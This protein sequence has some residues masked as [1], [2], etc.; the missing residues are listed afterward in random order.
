MSKDAQVKQET[1][2]LGRIVHYVQHDGRH[3]AGLI[4]GL[5]SGTRIGLTVFLP[6]DQAMQVMP[7]YF[8]IVGACELDSTGKLANTWHWPEKNG[9]LGIENSETT[10]VTSPALGAAD[11]EQPPQ[12][13]G[14]QPKEFFTTAQGPGGGSAGRQGCCGASCKAPECTAADASGR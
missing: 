9:E 2:S 14:E 11:D 8:L 7:H 6:P 12:L 4:T 5:H 13:A 1:P 10:H 3:T